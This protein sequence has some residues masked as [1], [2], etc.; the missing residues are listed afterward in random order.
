MKDLLYKYVKDG[1][2]TLALWREFQGYNSSALQYKNL[3]GRDHE[4]CTILPF[5][6]ILQKHKVKCKPS[7][8]N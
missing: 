7:S 8:L 5:F 2:V 1:H 4:G 3:D 6:F